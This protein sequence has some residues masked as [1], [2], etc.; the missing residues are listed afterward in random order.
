MDK[1]KEIW[2]SILYRKWYIGIGVAIAI[3]YFFVI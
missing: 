1:V 2:E 3:I